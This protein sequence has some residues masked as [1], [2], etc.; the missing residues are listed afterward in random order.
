ML[1]NGTDPCVAIPAASVTACCSAMPTSKA[2]SGIC[3]IIY[4][5]ELPVGMAGVIP[6]IFWFFLA[7]STKVKPNTS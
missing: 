6:I 2:R 3:S 4:F 5:K 1:Q 7:N